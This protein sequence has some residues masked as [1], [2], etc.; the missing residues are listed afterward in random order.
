MN[1]IRK[2][3]ESESAFFNAFLEGELKFSAS[4]YL[5]LIWIRILKHVFQYPNEAADHLVNHPFFKEFVAEPST[6]TYIDGLCKSLQSVCIGSPVRLP[7]PKRRLSEILDFKDDT[8]SDTETTIPPTKKSRVTW[9]SKSEED[10][11]PS[12]SQMASASNK[13]KKKHKKTKKH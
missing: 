7:R 4:L 1:K 6:E 9:H 8:E 13:N 11:L 2:Y 5:C 12:T 3:V 10:A